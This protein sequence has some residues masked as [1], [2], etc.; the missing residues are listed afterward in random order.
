M[1]A[2]EED[3]LEA[4]LE[5]FEPDP[6]SAA[7]IAAQKAVS[8]GPPAP[9]ARRLA[10]DP[11][12]E[13]AAGRARADDAEPAR[14][15]DA[16]ADD[17]PGV[18]LRERGARGGSADPHPRRAGR[19]PV[20]HRRR[21]HAA[22]GLPV[23]RQLPARRGRAAGQGQDAGGDGQRHPARRAGASLPAPERAPRGRRAHER[24]LPGRSASRRG[25]G[26]RR[27]SSPTW[28]RCSCPR[29][30]SLSVKISTIYSQ[31]SSL[32]FEDT[33]RGALR[34]AGAALPRRG[35][36]ALHPPGRN[37]WCRSSSTWTWRSTAT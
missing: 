22:Q 11:A 27:G 28:R 33:R 4:A 23:L 3:A 5:R 32:A 2:R 34:P 12:G 29:S 9:G 26:A 13:E 8:P 24:Q 25:G 15:G 30:R 16:D 1:Q 7:S 14:Q 19:A 10:A 18:S 37:A 17:R 35:E 31:I 36:D 6:A 20:L 21:P